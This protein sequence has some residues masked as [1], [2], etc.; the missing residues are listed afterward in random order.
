VV[1]AS[2][3]PP[4]VRD[5]FHVK[6][7]HGFAGVPITENGQLGGVLLGIVTSR[8]ID[9]REPTS[10][11][12]LSEVMTKRSDLITAKLGVSLED[13]NKILERSKKGKLPIIDDDDH[14]IALIARTDLKKSR[15][16]PWASR[17]ANDQLL[18]GAAISTREQDRRRLELLAKAGVDVVVLVIFI[19]CQSITVSYIEIMI[20]YRPY[21]TYPSF[22]S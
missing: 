5:V 19:F 11:Q 3:L 13:A 20:E 18:V 22:R 8:D 21:L 16:F 2:F 9:F 12:P 10:N 15:N 17:D 14:L 4:Q 7:K 6:E 1:T